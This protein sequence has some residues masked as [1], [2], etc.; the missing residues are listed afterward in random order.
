MT[1]KRFTMKSLIGKWER[2]NNQPRKEEYKMKKIHLT[3]GMPADIRR[4]EQPKQVNE[5]ADKIKNICSQ[6][7]LSYKE[8]NKALYLADK[9]LYMELI[10]IRGLG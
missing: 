7:G 1:K 8:K 3:D 4:T 9:E 10:S 2:C 6:S 5:L